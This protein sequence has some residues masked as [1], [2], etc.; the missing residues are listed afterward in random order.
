M[1]PLA[2]LR[3]SS[4]AKRGRALAVLSRV[5]LADKGARLPAQHSC[6]EQ[7]RVAIARALVNDPPLVLADEPPGA[8]DTRTGREIIG[9]FSELNRQGQTILLVTH[10][11]ENAS[12]SDRTIH[13]RDGRTDVK[14][15]APN[16]VAA[17]PR[18]AT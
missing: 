3:L 1:L 17:L 8:L 9:V 14:P 15:L 10:N 2:T 7:G 13:I 6:G 5:G 4:A 18:A 16:L 11:P 12:A